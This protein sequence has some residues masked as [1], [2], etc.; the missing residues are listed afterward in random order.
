[1]EKKDPTDLRLYNIII[2][3]VSYIIVR[4]EHRMILFFFMS[5]YDA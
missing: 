2:K 5:D 4:V 3:Y 1:M